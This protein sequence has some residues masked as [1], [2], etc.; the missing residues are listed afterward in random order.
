M[1]RIEPIEKNTVILHRPFLTNF[2]TF[3]VALNQ[4]WEVVEEI[5]FKIVLESTLILM[6]LT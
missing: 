4:S 3:F 1:F 2:D 5:D 6:G